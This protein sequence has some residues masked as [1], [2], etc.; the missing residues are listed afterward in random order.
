MKKISIIAAFACAALVV[1][2]SKA[3]NTFDRMAGEY[4]AEIS[5]AAPDGDYGDPGDPGDSGNSQGNGGQA[6]VVTAAEWNDLD[7]WGF[8][9]NLI[10][11][12]FKDYADIWRFNTEGRVAVFVST[13]EGV[14]VS[15]VTVELKEGED[16]LW[17]TVTDNYGRAECWLSLFDS[18]KQTD[19]SKLSVSINGIPSTEKPQITWLQNSTVRL[20]KYVVTNAKEPLLAADIAFI[21]DSTG[22]MMD[23]IDFLKK[24]LVDI[25]GKVQQSQSGLKIRT[26]AVFYRDEG[27]DYLTLAS[28]FTEDLSKTSE[29]IKAQT[30]DGGGDFPEAVHTALEIS[31]QALSWNPDAHAR[32]AFMLLDAPAHET[33]YIK[34]SLHE[35]IRLYAQNGIKLIP[36]SAS[37]IDKKTEAMLRFFSIGTN[38]TYV[39]I[40]ND[41][42]VGGNH[43]EASVGEYQVEK[44]NDLIVRLI[45]KYT[46]VITSAP[47]EDTPAEDTPSEDTPTEDPE[48]GGTP[49]A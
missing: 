49:T 45:D 27:D 11:G 8:W 48:D 28:Y 44:L 40:T 22:S 34:E 18:N 38:A 16:L 15:G 19:Q 12:Q 33:D 14:P 20:N 13:E 17:K 36:V 37:G 35:S 5:P 7:N 23:E 21:V 26:G 42:G 29:F 46:A 2:C 39:F 41:S 1:S 31:L 47:S 30:A 3:S 10:T 24:D 32:I 9:G 6:G 25:I 43:I 4:D